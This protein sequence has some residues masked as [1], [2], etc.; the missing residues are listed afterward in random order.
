MASY[1]QYLRTAV[2]FGCN[3]IILDTTAKEMAAFE[4]TAADQRRIDVWYLDEVNGQLMLLLAYL[5]TRRSEWRDAT[6]RVLVPVHGSSDVPRT[7]EEVAAMLA[8]FRITAEARMVDRLDL[9]HVLQHSRDATL[10][11]FP[12]QL[13]GDEP[14][15]VFDGSL[16]EMLK[17]LPLTALVLAAQEIDLDAEPEEGPQQQIVEAI[18]AAAVAKEKAGKAVRAADDARVVLEKLR[19]ELAE[20]RNSDVD[21]LTL[22]KLE[23]ELSAA[24]QAAKDLDRR[25]AKVSTKADTAAREADEFTGRVATEENQEPDA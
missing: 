19:G 12:F 8:E 15:C 17:A 24:E 4:S 16:D 20:A 22:E 1:R 14:A 7:E 5:M 13:A 23:I 3:L 21:S 9:Q 10:V 18:D 25:A 11:F 6:L 2:R